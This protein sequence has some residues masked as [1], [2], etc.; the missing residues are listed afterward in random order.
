MK[1]AIKVGGVRWYELSHSTMQM[2][3]LP[4]RKVYLHQDLFYSQATV[5]VVGSRRWDEK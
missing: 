5:N 2:L 3:R 4:M 1:V